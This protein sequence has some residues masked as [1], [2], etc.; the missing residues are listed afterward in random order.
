MINQRSIY[1]LKRNIFILTKLRIVIQNLNNISR[2]F[3]FKILKLKFS[4]DKYS[5]I[6][7]IIRNRNRKFETRSSPD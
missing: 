2:Y 3:D 1:T 7:S 5:Y 6:N 4:N